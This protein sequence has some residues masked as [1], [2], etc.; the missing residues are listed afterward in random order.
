MTNIIFLVSVLILATVVDAHAYLDPNSGTGLIAFL[1][2]IFAGIAFYSK[3]IFYGIKS[4]FKKNKN[5]N[6]EGK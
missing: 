4:L 3:K 2:A 6:G 5:E 1:V